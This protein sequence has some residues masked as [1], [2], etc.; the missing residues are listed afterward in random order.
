M[1]WDKYKIEK[2]TELDTRNSETCILL[3][4]THLVL[5]HRIILNNNTNNNNIEK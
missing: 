5:M 1:A 2:L 4:D 3:E